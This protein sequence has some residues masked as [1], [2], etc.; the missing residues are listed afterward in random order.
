MRDDDP[1]LENKNRYQLVEI[2]RAQTPYKARREAPFQPGGTSSDGSRPIETATIIIDPP[3]HEGLQDL[4]SFDRIWLLYVFNR[5]SGFKLRVKPPRGDG[6]RGL[7]ATRSPHRP[8]NIGMTCA[9]L[10]EVKE[11]SLIVA[12]IDL[13]DDTPIVDIKPYLHYSDAFPDASAGWV[14]ELL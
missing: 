13:L 2:G 14:E 11:R 10:I 5:N 8:S 6:K 1:Q 7:F 3:F 12:E 4:A 9:K